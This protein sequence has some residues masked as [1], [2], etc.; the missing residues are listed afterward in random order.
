MEKLYD[1]KA[2]IVKGVSKNGNTYYGMLVYL[3]KDYP[4]FTILQN[5]DRELVRNM[6]SNLPKKEEKNV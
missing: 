3:T 2:E 5:A 4:M 1:T 6:E